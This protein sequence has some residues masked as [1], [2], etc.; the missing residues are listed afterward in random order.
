MKNLAA[1]AT[2]TLFA[3]M[4]ANG[5]DNFKDVIIP[6]EKTEIKK[7]EP[8][9]TRKVD[10]A[11]NGRRIIY[12]VPSSSSVDVTRVTMEKSLDSGSLKV[13][14]DYITKKFNLKLT[15]IKRV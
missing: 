13:N 12:P 8:P 9:D 5:Q 1:L 4:A 2:I 14:A 15:K 3:V 7:A 11:T 10:P 6:S